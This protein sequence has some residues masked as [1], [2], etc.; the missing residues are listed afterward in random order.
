MKAAMDAPP[1]HAG[2]IHPLSLK[3]MAFLVLSLAMFGPLRGMAQPA[4]IFFGDSM[5]PVVSGEAWLIANRWGFDQGILVA[6][7][8]EGKLEARET[9]QFP[10][11]WEQGF[12]YKLLLAVSAKLAEPPK[13][14]ETDDAYGW[15]DRW[16]EYLKSFSTV[17]VS[18][19]LAAEKRGKDWATALR[20]MGHLA[21]RDLILP[22]P[23]R[24]KI[25][26]LYPDGQPLAGA[27]VL[28]SS[29]GSSENHCGVAVGI[30]LGALTTN[31]DGEISVIATYAPVA[32]TRGYFDEEAG[33]PAG[34]AFA[35]RENMIIGGDPVTTVKRLWTLP[36]HDYLLHLRT[37][38]NQPITHARLTACMNFDGCGAGC[39]PIRAPESDASGTIRF[40]EE[41]LRKMRSLTVVSQEGKE[42]NLTDSEMRELL[43]TY[44]LNL[45][46]D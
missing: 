21:D 38:G 8:R 36:E 31:A 2:L 5:H 20:Q 9:A 29:Y 41:D 32:L 33:G 26:L 14:V 11:H 45:R 30:T 13:S 23:T 7:I 12:D 42:R 46:W 4:R 27:R 19:P 18:A 16:P 37:V 15:F 28:L 17:Y 22:L 3:P 39:G 1:S 43:T 6:T 34:T 25:C 24:R 10:P 40:R 35:L 44:Q